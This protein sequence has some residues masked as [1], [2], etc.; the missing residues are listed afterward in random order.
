MSYGVNKKEDQRCMNIALKTLE[1]PLAEFLVQFVSSYDFSPE[2]PLI[3]NAR[4]CLPFYYA[5]YS[6]KLIGWENFSRG[7]ILEKWKSIQYLYCLQE[8]TK[9]IHT[10]D[11]WARMLIEQL[12]ECHRVM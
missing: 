7:R 2:E 4:Y 12:L 6:Q 9:D 5:F 10:V 1:L 11:K 3:G 8:K